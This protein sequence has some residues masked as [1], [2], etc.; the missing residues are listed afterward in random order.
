MQP[1]TGDAGTG[2]G[3]NNANSHVSIFRADVT[4]II[5]HRRVP[6]ISEV[7]AKI[8]LPVPPASQKREGCFISVKRQPLLYRVLSQLCLL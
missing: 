8:K 3:F 4:D 6:D 7:S 2:A 1:Q 5:R